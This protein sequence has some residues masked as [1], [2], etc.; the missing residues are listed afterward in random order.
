MAYKLKKNQ[1]EF[2]VVDGP[3]AGKK[4]RHNERYDEVPPG[5]KDRFEVVKK[6][7]QNKAVATVAAKKK[8][9]L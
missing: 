6:P 9:R 1:P 8:R 7:R 4:Y 5:D 3:F 2:D